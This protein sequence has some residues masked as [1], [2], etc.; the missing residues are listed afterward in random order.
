MSPRARKSLRR[1]PRPPARLPKR[2]PGPAGA[3]EVPAGQVLAEWHEMT[4]G[5][6]AVEWS[7]LRAWVT[8]LHGRYE[9]SVE[10]R[11]PRC[12][13][14][15]PGLVEELSALRAWRTE[16]YAC[17]QP[18]GGQAA[19][20][21]HSELRRVIQAAT[22]VYAAGCRTGHRG[23]PAPA[24]TGAKAFGEPG[25]AGP[26]AGV[27]RIDIVAG[28]ARGTSDWAAGEEIAIALDLGEAW[29]VPGSELVRR[30]G[31]CWAAAAG[32]WARVPEWAR[33]PGA[34]AGPGTGPHEDRQAGPWTR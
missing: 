21:W 24:G 32:G 16:I 7:G 27:P 1:G 29:Q 13:A 12:W 8:W 15:H 26:L 11:L 20:Y 5:Q 2:R 3:A 4:P 17:E 25:G 23:A 10:E 22:T 6:L 19:L 34:S 28:Q 31:T 14:L 18:G 30:A 9:L 33:A